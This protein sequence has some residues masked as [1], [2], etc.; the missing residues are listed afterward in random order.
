M[1]GP[2]DDYLIHQT[3]EPLRLVQTSDRRFYDRYFF[4]GHRCDDQLF[5]ML[6]MGCYP[7]LGVIDA[8]ASVA[9]GTVQH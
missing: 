6:G 9:Y 4:T 7:N 1:L 8:F 3:H 5:F 2:A